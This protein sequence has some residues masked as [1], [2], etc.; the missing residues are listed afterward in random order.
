MS[1]RPNRAEQALNSPVPPKQQAG[2]G[3]DQWDQYG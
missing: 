3:R 2:S 1:G